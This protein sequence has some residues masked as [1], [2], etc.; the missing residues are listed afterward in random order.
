MFSKAVTDYVRGHTGGS[1]VGEVVETHYEKG[2]VVA[3]RVRD[4]KDGKGYR[5]CLVSQ[6]VTSPSFVAGRAT[7]GYWAV[8]ANTKEIGFLKDTW[9]LCRDNTDL[10]GG[11]LQRLNAAGVRNVPSLICHG[12]VGKIPG[13]TDQRTR[14]N[15]YMACPWVCR[16]SRLRVVPHVH[17]RMFTRLA[18]YPLSSFKDSKELL[19]CARDVYHAVMDAH[20]ANLLH[21]DISTGNIIVTR[22]KERNITAYLINWEL[23]ADVKSVHHPEC[24]DLT[25]IWQFMSARLICGKLQKPHNIYDDIESIFWVTLYEILQHLPHEHGRKT[26]TILR[27]IFDDRIDLD[28]TPTG[29][30]GDAKFAVLGLPKYISARDTPNTTLCTW[31]NGLAS[32]LYPKVLAYSADLEESTSSAPSRPTPNSEEILA[33][34]S[35][36]DVVENMTDVVQK[37]LRH[38]SGC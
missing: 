34:S 24:T 7:R 26:H 32:F 3:L 28:G 2:H 14:T 17:Y 37:V 16:S 29:G 13:L 19:K 1:R 35:I 4:E 15:E 9:R 30:G 18:G 11:V 21:R 36:F 12:D 33:L 6:P 5:R 27:S 22:D 20:R 25:G 23:Y 8:D 10:E 31:L 38:P